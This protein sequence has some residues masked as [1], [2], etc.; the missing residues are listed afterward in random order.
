M[1]ELSFSDVLRMHA[2]L[3]SAVFFCFYSGWGTHA[4]TEVHT[5]YRKRSDQEKK[6]Q[7]PQVRS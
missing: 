3:T 7:R 6:Y 1:L 4:K 5:F 2:P